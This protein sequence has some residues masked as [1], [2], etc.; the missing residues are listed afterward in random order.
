MYSGIAFILLPGILTGLYLLYLSLFQVADLQDV[1]NQKRT[2]HTNEVSLC[3]CL[4][5]E[6][7]SGEK[8]DIH[9]NN[10]VTSDSDGLPDHSVPSKYYPNPYI[11]ISISLPKP[12]HQRVDM[13]NP[14]GQKIIL[15]SKAVHPGRWHFKDR[16]SHLKTILLIA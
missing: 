4:L 10:T 7:F 15:L 12:G 16:P 2:R 8:V 1:V 6:V 13:I 14:L 11:P 9:K 3:D 5:A